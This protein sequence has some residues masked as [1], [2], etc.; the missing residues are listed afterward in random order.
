MRI[1]SSLY[2]WLCV[3]YFLE[4]PNGCV[5]VGCYSQEP[6]WMIPLATIITILKPRFPMEGSKTSISSCHKYALKIGAFFMAYSQNGNCYLSK[7]NSLVEAPRTIPECFHNNA[8]DT[9]VSL[10]Y[11]LTRKC[12]NWNLYMSLDPTKQSSDELPVQHPIWNKVA[13]MLVVEAIPPTSHFF[14]ISL[15]LNDP[16]GVTRHLSFWQY[17]VA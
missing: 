12:R 17:M 16:I 10:V 7:Q 3:V 13:S 8:G 15:F 1:V 14:A 11:R 5:E 9:E 2:F 6:K 4:V